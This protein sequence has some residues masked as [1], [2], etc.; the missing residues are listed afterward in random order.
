[1]GVGN[2]YRGRYGG[3]CYITAFALFIS[4]VII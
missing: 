2:I 4:L 3:Q 1:M